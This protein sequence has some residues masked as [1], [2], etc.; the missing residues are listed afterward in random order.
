MFY[1]TIWLYKLNNC[2][3]SFESDSD[4]AFVPIIKFI[5]NHGIEVIFNH[6]NLSI[7]WN[8]KTGKI[9]SFSN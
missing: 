3:F 8:N 6:L 9:K 1:N 4:N 5:E 2:N 7:T